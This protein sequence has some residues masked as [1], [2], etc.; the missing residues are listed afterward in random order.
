GLSPSP[1]A[2]KRTLIRRLSFD[3]LGLPPT[4]EDVAAFEKGDSPQ[5]YE[6][7]VN[8]LLDSPHYG[9]RWGRHWLD[10]VRFGESQGFERDK[11]RT[12]S[13]QYRDWVISAFNDDMPY[14]EFVRLQ[15][16]GDTLL[17]HDPGAVIATGFLVAAPYDEVGQTQQS[18]A[19]R[20]V[21]RQDE[22]E[23]LIGVTGQTFLGLT[24]NCARCHDHKFDPVLQS[25]YYHLSAVLAG[26]RHG[27]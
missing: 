8:R 9:E 1:P 22:L 27:E 12:N 21:V 25:E 10:I 26:V 16:A 20:A 13:W 14:D 4:H 11:L 17:P 19:M 3:L 7:L 15:L 2:E 5:A 18:L 24:V 6:K 23:D